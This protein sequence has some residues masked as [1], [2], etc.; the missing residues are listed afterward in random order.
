MILLRK[1]TKKA[2]IILSLLSISSISGSFAEQVSF[3]KKRIEDGYQFSYVWRD[4]KQQTQHLS[5]TLSNEQLFDRYR[6]FSEYHPQIAQ[7]FVNN[8]LRRYVVT[9]P[10]PGVYVV[11]DN[12]EQG[13]IS[14]KIRGKDNKLI[15]ETEQKLQSLGQ[16]FK[17]SYLDKIYYHEFVTPDND[18]A[19]KPDHPRIAMESVDDFKLLKDTIIKKASIKNIRRVTNFVLGFVQNIPYSTLES[20]LTSSGAGFNPPTK[21]LW[22][23]QGDCDSK[24]TLT[25][26]LLRMLMPRI[27]MAMVFIE[28]HALIGIELMPKAGDE[29]IEHNGVFYV[30]A[31]PTGP[32][33]LEIGTIDEES[34]LAINSGYYSLNLFH[35]DN[36]ETEG[37]M[38][39]E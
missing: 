11:L 28:G 13:Q 24:V 36:S 16:E 12:P 6:N 10:T 32:A 8:A 27:K 38:P 29:Y 26:S 34:S 21:L 3:T 15:Q 4:V 39:S 31:E 7:E 9:N 30:L 18:I 33:L 20:R 22:E 1:I 17:K 25:A 14:A 35:A 2:L 5:F 23:N 37:D 19:V